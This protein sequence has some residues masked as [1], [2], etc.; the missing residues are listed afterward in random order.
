MKISMFGTGVVGQTIA[1]KLSGL[2]HD[3][4]VGTREPAATLARVEKDALG[5][6]PFRDWHA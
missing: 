2:G 3:V 5:F 4:M 1:A 6:P